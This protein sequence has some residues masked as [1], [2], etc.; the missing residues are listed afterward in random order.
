[1][2]K[3]TH[4]NVLVVGSINMDVVT[5]IDQLPLP[6]ETIMAGDVQLIAGGKGANAAV[7]AAR[8]GGHVHMIG[9]VGD[10]AFGNT[11]KANLQNEGINCDR[12]AVIKDI[13]SGTAVILLDKQSGQNSIMVSAGA[14]AKV[15]EAKDESVYTWANVLMMQLETPVCVNVESAKRAKQAGITVI[16]DP[17][18]AISDLP[19][20]L[21]ACCDIL[22]PNETS[23]ATLTG[24]DT[25]SIPQVVAA[26]K[27]LLKRGSKHI[28]V[29]LG[30][31]G[32]IWV[33]QDHNQH[34]TTMPVTPIDTTAAGDSF[35]GAL[36]ANLARG[37]SIPESIPF[38][39][40]A[41]TLACTK[42]GAQP[43]IPTTDAVFAFI[44]T[45]PQT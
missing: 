18:P 29:T 2:P 10:D 1:M 41:G 13:S 23:L 39:L 26:S 28:I 12:V 5:P 24:M 35:A 25:D 30:Q 43:S 44:N 11:L 7:A 31:R 36:A 3:H 20:E 45:S 6:G 4:G 32:A 40:A 21:F 8:L 33:T 9:A 34:F 42:L 15:T 16:L 22:L 14:N 38:A 37:Q 17:A 19:D 27:A